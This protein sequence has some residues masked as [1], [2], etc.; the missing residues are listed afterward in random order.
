MRKPIILHFIYDLGCGG[1]E[2]MLVNSIEYLNDYEHVLV[3]LLDKN[4]FIELPFTK[5]FNLNCGSF[6]KLP[7]AILKF[8][9]IIKDVGPS[10]I[11]SHL[12]LPNII[13]RFSTSSEIPLL[14]H[15]HTTVSKSTSYT[16]RH[17]R[18]IERLSNKFR[19]AEV[20][21]VSENTIQDYCVFFQFPREKCRILYTYAN[22]NIFKPVKSNGYKSN[23][24]RMVTVGTKK[25]K[26]V[27]FLIQSLIIL[28]E[29]DILLDIYGN[30]VSSPILEKAIEK[31][32][33]IHYKGHSSNIEDIIPNYD[34]YISA[35][36]LEGFSLSVLEAMACKLALILSDIPSFHEQAGE[37]AFYFDLKSTDCLISLLKDCLEN[38]GVIIDK[39]DQTFDRYCHNFTL[40][41]Y[42]NEL[43]SLYNE[44]VL[45]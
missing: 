7:L 21:G 36:R 41:I 3:T 44:K 40:A 19:Q 35:S 33:P 12:P 4:D 18:L 13:A 28:N 45:T 37:T 22:E 25:S 8:K 9:K 16:K 11:H 20:I 2:K 42:I 29:R 38:P 34:I 15:I 24:I 32:L 26:N 1:A 31:K 43:N 23:K 5:T 39:A 6:F 17:I 14:T 10:L 30:L 27:E